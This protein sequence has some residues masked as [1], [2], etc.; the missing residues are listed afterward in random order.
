MYVGLADVMQK[1]TIIYARRRKELP[2]KR[3]TSEAE[4][5]YRN[6]RYQLPMEKFVCVPGWEDVASYHCIQWFIQDRLDNHENENLDVLMEEIIDEGKKFV[7]Q[8]EALLV[9]AIKVCDPSQI[10]ISKKRIMGRAV[11]LFFCTCKV[12]AQQ[13]TDGFR[14]VYGYP[15][16]VDHIMKSEGH[17]SKQPPSTDLILIQAARDILKALGLPENSTREALKDFGNVCCQCGHWGCE[18]P[19]AFERLVSILIDPIRFLV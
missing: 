5:Y 4:S 7:P 2:T 17:W 9:D 16:I 15:E 6:H 19:I 12:C 10:R 1:L 13:M 18:K 14:N 11:N 8:F 3:S